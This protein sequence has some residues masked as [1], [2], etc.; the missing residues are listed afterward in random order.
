[1]QEIEFQALWLSFKLAFVTTVLLMLVCVPLAR[2]LTFSRSRWVPFVRTLTAMP[3][4][5]PPTVLGFYLLQLLGH[6]GWFGQFFLQTTGVSLV[7][8]FTGLV[9]ASTIYSLPFVVQPMTQAFTTTADKHLQ[10]ARLLGVSD[11]LAFRKIILPLSNNG[12]INAA[13]LGFAHTLGEFGVVLMIGGNIPGETRVVSIAIFDHVESL[14][15][16]SAHVLSGIL[17]VLSFAILWFVYQRHSQS[18]RHV[19]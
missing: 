8:S 5:L 19:I 9:V 15:Y 16:V 11:G 12:L 3:L 18:L 14:N 17:L 2:W 7:F 4:I 1:M 10:E 6:N 13:V